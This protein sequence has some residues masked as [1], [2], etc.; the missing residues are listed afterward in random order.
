MYLLDIGDAIASLPE[1]FNK[2]GYSCGFTRRCVRLHHASC[3]GLLAKDKQNGI[4]HDR[5]IDKEGFPILPRGETGD[6]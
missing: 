5:H 2:P 4:I 3:K 1:K 6:R